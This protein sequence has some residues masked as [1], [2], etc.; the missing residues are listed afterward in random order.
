MDFSPQKNVGNR[1]AIVS[2]KTMLWYVLFVVLLFGVPVFDN[3]KSAEIPD[4]FKNKRH[5][6]AGETPVFI[7]IADDQDERIKG[8]SG[9]SELKYGEGMLFIFD[10]EK[11]HGIWM[12]DMNFA[13]D[14]IWL[15]ENLQVVS[16]KENATPES[17]PESFKPE[18]KALYVLE[19]PSGFV[20]K[21]G[22]KINDQ[23]TLF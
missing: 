5:L 10:N 18:R 4:V 15:D 11:Y 21:E 9:R 19:V 1:I 8:L 16:I 2:A 14:I 12:K 23:I 3:L 6:F 13:I 7:E 22:I 20:K 17:Y